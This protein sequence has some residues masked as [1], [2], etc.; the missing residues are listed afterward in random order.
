MFEFGGKSWCSFH[1]PTEDAEG[2]PS[3]KATWT[4]DELNVLFLEP[5]GER[6][7]LA[8]QN[9]EVLDLSF[10]VFAHDHVF[11]MQVD[12]DIDALKGAVPMLSIRCD[13]ARFEGMAFFK[14]IVFGP[15]A[16]FQGVLFRKRVDFRGSS[17]RWAPHFWTAT[18]EDI[19]QFMS[20]PFHEG[21]SFT[22]AHFRKSADFSNAILTGKVELGSSTWEETAKFSTSSSDHA[23]RRIQSLDAQAAVFKKGVSFQNRTFEG[24]T[25]FEKAVFGLAPDFH[26]CTLHQATY[27][28]RI[29]SFTDTSSPRAASCYRTLAQ[30][31]ADMRAHDEEAM[32]FA[33]QQRALRTDRAWHDPIRLFSVFYD[34]TSTYGQ[35]LMKP[36]LLF[37]L[38]LLAAVA[39][40]AVAAHEQRGT[41]SQALAAG[42]A[43]ASQQLLRPFASWSDID[44]GKW[45][46]CALG[47]RGVLWPHYVGS[48]QTLFTATWLYL[49]ALGIRWRFRRW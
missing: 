24:T 38:T 44:T 10:A 36:L 20:V 34:C 32:F 15:S 40:Y 25:N 4:K 16:S 39:I 45:P 14:D 19:A 8:V 30:F 47:I 23:E 18:F 11:L 42:C 17:F 31:A 21:A 33:L 13:F 26:G 41:W 12:G 2:N 48:L 6:L 43:F 9:R 46:L 22:N 7:R 28:P 27:F 1:L 37:T 49:A 5:L 35:S 3:P 29:D